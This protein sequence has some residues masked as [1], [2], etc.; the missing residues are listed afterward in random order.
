MLLA[1]VVALVLALPIGVGA[2]ILVTTTATPGLLAAALA[3]TAMTWLT[4]GLHLDGLAD[5]AD[6]LGSGKDAEGA[7]AIARRS[8]IGP[9]GV[10][11]IVLVLLLQVTALGALLDAGAGGGAL[12]IAMVIG[13]LAIMLACTPLWHPARPDG[14]GA[15]VSGT[16][17]S[18]AALLVTVGWLALF[19]GSVGNA[20]GTAAAAATSLAMVVAIG[21]AILLARI[22]TRRLGGITGDV[23]GAMN[24]VAVTTSLVLIVVT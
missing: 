8:D 20:H 3:V 14:L 9:F 16:V 6:A 1:P 7:L 21:V 5:T 15:M 18:W 4:R 17:P 12:V 11:S 2:Q 13:R 19:A 10:V 23:L 24:E 22:C